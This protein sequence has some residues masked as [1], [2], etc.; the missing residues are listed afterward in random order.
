MSVQVSLQ[1]LTEAQAKVIDKL[2]TLTESIADEF[3]QTVRSN[4]FALVKDASGVTLVEGSVDIADLQM[5]L[6]SLL[7]E[8]FHSTIKLSVKRSGYDFYFNT[9]AKSTHIDRCLQGQEQGVQ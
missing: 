6:D 8:E 7:P 1:R 9:F 4:N 5:M 2:T 3:V